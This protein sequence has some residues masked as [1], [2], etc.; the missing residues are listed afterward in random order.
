MATYL[1][2]SEASFCIMS[3]EAAQLQGCEDNCKIPLEL[4]GGV[5]SSWRES[6]HP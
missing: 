5:I 6:F 3:R 1:G 4:S 2:E